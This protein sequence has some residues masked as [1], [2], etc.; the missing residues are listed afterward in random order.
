[1]VRFAL[2]TQRQTIREV[3]HKNAY[4]RRLKAAHEAMMF[5]LGAFG[6]SWRQLPPPGP[7]DVLVRPYR[8]KLP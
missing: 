8:P 2:V 7:G 6:V 4:A 5:E 3:M 1:M